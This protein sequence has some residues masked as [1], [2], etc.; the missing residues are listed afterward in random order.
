MGFFDVV[1]K[2]FRGE[3]VFSVKPSGRPQQ[4]PNKLGDQ[5]KSTGQKAVPQVMVESWQCIEQ[6]SGL[7]C[8]IQIRNYS[9]GDVNLQR[10]DL[11]GV[12]DE[13]G[14]HLDAGER[15][16]YYFNLANRP[17]DTH[18]DECDL[19][20]RNEEGDYFLAKHQVEFEKQ[21][22]GTYSILRFRLIPPIRD[23]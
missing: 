13:V 19:Y 10:V 8:E 23:V 9:Q 1:G 14:E 11:L 7:R 16:E 20:F 4:Q 3:P 15:Y 12:R 6:G 18:A 17:K 21:P 22:D 5:Q 2:M